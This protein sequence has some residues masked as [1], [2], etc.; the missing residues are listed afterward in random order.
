MT[1]EPADRVGL[2]TVALEWTRIGLTGFGGP[3][4][5]IASRRHRPLMFRARQDEL[6]ARGHVVNPRHPIEGG[7][8]LSMRM[9]FSA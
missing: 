2:G 7:R 4:A 3:P 8:E 5:H 1:A 6:V 9:L